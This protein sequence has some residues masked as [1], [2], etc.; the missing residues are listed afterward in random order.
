MK[1]VSLI[2]VMF[3]VL[4]SCE[5]T[6][7]ICNCNTPIED[8]PWLKQLK[9]S[10]T[11][12]TCQIS[13]FQATHKKQT[14]FYMIMNDPLCDG[15]QQIVLLDCNGN[16]IKSYMPNDQAFSSEVTNREVIFTCKTKK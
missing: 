4:L 5:K 9:S 14:A 1:K 11:N 3:I 7:K 15:Y 8:L 6:D 13:V 10:I 2:F 12:C 16:N